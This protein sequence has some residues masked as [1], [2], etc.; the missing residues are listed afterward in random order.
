MIGVQPSRRNLKNEIF[1]FEILED[2]GKK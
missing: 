2:G 1:G